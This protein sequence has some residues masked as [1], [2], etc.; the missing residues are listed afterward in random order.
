M[1]TFEVIADFGAYRDLQRH[2]ILT[3]ERQLLTCNHGYYTP[4]ELEMSGLEKEYRTAMEAAEAAFTL[5]Q[6]SFLK[7]PSTL[8]RWPTISVGI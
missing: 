2:R 1:F 4:K 3:Q 5:F 8:C 7:K 6:K